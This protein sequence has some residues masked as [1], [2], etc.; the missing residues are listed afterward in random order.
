MKFFK[1]VLAFIFS[2]LVVSSYANDLENYENEVLYKDGYI[3]LPKYMIEKSNL[4]PDEIL[5]FF[6]FNCVYCHSLHAY[7]ETWADTLPDMFSLKYEPVIIDD[8]LYHL[9]AAAWIYISNSN[10]SIDMKNKYMTNIYKYLPRV[11]GPK[12]LTRLIKES[13]NDVGADVKDFSQRFYLGE[14]DTVIK[15]KQERQRILNIQYTPSVVIGD[16]FLTHLGL[17]DGKAKEFI[18][19]LNAVTSYFIYQDREDANK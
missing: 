8:P 6:D 14:Y 1:Y 17:A 5:Y 12:K 16:K 7:M 13:F 3:E 10:L 15:E 2:V 4:A 9:N 18:T 11:S 19:L